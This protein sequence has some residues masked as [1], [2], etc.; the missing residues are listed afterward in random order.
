MEFSGFR[1]F[2]CC[3]RDA[4][5]RPAL[6]RAIISQLCHSVLSRR[7]RFGSP[8][9]LPSESY[10]RFDIYPEIKYLLVANSARVATDDHISRAGQLGR[11]PFY[12]RFVQTTV[13]CTNRC[14]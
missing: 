2:I 6:L 10:T 13:A 11:H 7:T 14:K 1:E 8:L 3:G 5:R 9:S 4:T 12:C